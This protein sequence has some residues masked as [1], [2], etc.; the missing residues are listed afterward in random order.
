M[1]VDGEVEFEIDGEIVRPPVGE[2]VLIPAGAVHSVRNIGKTTSRWLYGYK[3]H[4]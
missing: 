1:V 2:E 4:K 3:T